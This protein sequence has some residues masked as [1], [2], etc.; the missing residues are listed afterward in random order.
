TSVNGAGVD[1]QWIGIDSNGGKSAVGAGAGAGRLYFDYDNIE[2][3]GKGGAGGNQLVMNTSVDG[4]H[5]GNKCEAAEIPC[6]LPPAVITRDE[7][8][9]GNVVVDNAPRS[10]YQHRVYAIHTTRNSSG[11]NVSWCQGAKGDKTAAQVS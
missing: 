9:P 11:V 5:Y 6:L 2:R 10:A 1:R 3:N 4:V 8:I 7:G